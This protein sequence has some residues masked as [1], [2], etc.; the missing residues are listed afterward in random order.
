MGVDPIS[1]GVMAVGTGLQAYNQHDTARRQNRS[2]LEGLAK[3]KADQALADARVNDLLGSIR[4]SN[5]QG[6]QA[7][8]KS[9]FLNQLRA[10]A[11]TTDGSFTNTPGASAR[12]QQDLATS[13][14]AVGDYGAGQADLL[15]R[16]NAPQFQRAAE[17]NMITR[18]AGDLS[19]LGSNAAGDAAI[20]NLNTQA[21]VPNPWLSMLSQVLTGAGGALNR[22]GATKKQF[23]SGS[24]IP[25]YNANPSSYI[26]DVGLQY[27]GN[28]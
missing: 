16:V 4:G 28:G 15:S 24:G 27:N 5:A 13:K 10:N 17:G 1:L 20:S 9:D 12:Y 21:Q 7:A 25:S 19:R 23:P 18:A 11:S 26:S 3:Q 8:N 6:V 14:A 2:L 22:Y